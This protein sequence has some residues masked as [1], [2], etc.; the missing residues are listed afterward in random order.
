M[1]PSDAS[2]PPVRSRGKYLFLFILFT[3][4]LAAALLI[5][6]RQERSRRARI[7]VQPT[8]P[9]PPPPSTQRPATAPTNLPLPPPTLSTTPPPVV[10]IPP[11]PIDNPDAERA[12]QLIRDANAAILSN[13]APTAESLALQAL[14]LSPDSVPALLIL[15]H[16]YLLQ[17]RGP[18][19]ITTLERALRLEPFNPQALL[20]LSLAYF[21]SGNSDE[22]LDII[23]T[24]LRVHPTNPAAPLQRALILLTIPDR[25][26]DCI[27]AFESALESHPNNAGARSNYAIALSRARRY[28]DAIAQIDRSIALVPGSYIFHQ[29]RATFCTAAGHLPEALESLRTALSLAPFDKRGDILNDPDLAP[30]RALPEFQPIATEF[31]PAFDTLLFPQGPSQEGATKN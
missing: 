27:A 9:V 28:D 11:S 12:L 29:H 15:G 22:A 14:D 1:P 7:S 5:V 6:A 24:L 20:D 23:D 21:L 16:S 13:D 17:G 25:L 2:K 8:Q 10:V 3:L 31:D 19:I 4:A 26:D 18:D 30:L